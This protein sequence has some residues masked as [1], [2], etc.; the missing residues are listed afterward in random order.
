MAVSLGRTGPG[1]DSVN[2]AA[3][4]A[5]AF[6]QGASGNDAL[7]AIAGSN[8]LDGGMGSNFP[9]GATGADGGADTFFLDDRRGGSTWDTL[10]NFHV[11][12]AVTLWGFV[13]GQST[14]SW[15]GVGGAPRYQGAT[16][17]A[18]FTG[19]GASGTVTFAGISLAD[20]QSKFTT[21]TGTAGGISYL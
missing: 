18:S 4:V 9:N 3:N 6:L 7:S 11:G 8:V 21:S 19:G 17:N 14:M 13:P 5:N 16:L 12:D 2:I 10:V 15:A 1:Q 20:A